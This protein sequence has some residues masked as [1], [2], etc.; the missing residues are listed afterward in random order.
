[1]K[2][3][4]LSKW[5]HKK[6]MYL[7]LLNLIIFLYKIEPSLLSVCGIDTPI[8]KNGGDCIIGKCSASLFE[9][10]VCTIENDIIRTQWLTSVIG[11]SDIAIN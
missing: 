5:N 8:K 4:Y 10:G 1:M 2:V 11:Y 7:L 6:N 9:S 3:A